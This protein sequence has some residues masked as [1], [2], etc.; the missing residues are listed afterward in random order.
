MSRKKRGSGDKS[1]SGLQLEVVH[2]HAAGIDIG[3]SE[4][5]VAVDPRVDEEP[6]RRF[7]ASWQIYTNWRIG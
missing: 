2:R 5:Y 6:V 7:G 3:G 4:H 1:L